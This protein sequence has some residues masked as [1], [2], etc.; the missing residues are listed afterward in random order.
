MISI[1]SYLNTDR[2]RSSDRF[3][4]Y[5][6]ITVHNNSNAKNCLVNLFIEK[7]YYCILFTT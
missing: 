2:S 5:I 7:F 1:I 6:K 4:N 3:R